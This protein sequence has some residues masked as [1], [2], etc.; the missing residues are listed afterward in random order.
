MK[1]LYLAY[2]SNLNKTQMAWRCPDAKPVAVTWLPGYAL[3]FQ[4][5]RWNA[6]AN[7]IPAEGHSVPVAIWTISP[8][9][10]ANL[11]IYEGVRGGYY[12]KEYLEIDVNGQK[13][14]A[15]IYI[16]TPNPYGE[17]TEPYYNTIET[18]YKDFGLDPEYLERALE[19]SQKQMQKK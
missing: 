6:H 13:E 14:K 2:G 10:E 16:M 5:R 15:L 12:T 19:F 4:G 11:D 1:K 3:V 9:D 7:V 8:E 17:P 18:G